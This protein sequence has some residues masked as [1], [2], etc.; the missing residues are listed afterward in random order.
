MKKL[1]LFIVLIIFSTTLFSQT[2][3][4]SGRVIDAISGEALPF[5]NIIFGQKKGVTTDINGRYTIK[6]TAPLD[7]IYLSFIGYQSKFFKIRN[8]EERNSVSILMDRKVFELKE[9][10]VIP[11]ENPAHRII[12]EAIK[13]RDNNNPLKNSSFSYTSYNKMV[14]TS[15]VLKDTSAMRAYAD[16][17][18][19]DSVSKMKRRTMKFFIDQ[20]LFM[21]ESVN[22][23][24]FKAPD[25]NFEKVIATKISGFKDPLF[26]LL[27]TQVQS[28]SFYNDMFLLLDKK[29]VNPI[30]SGSTSKYYFEIQDTTYR[31]NDTVFIISYRPRR[32]TN[33]DGLKGL[34]YINTNEYA[35][36]NVIAEPAKESGGFNISIQ[37]QYELIEQKK[38][39]PVQ[40]N[41]NFS[42]KN[43]QANGYQIIGNGTSFIQDIKLN[44]ALKNR[45]FGDTEVDLDVI[46]PEKSDTYLAHYRRDTLTP[47]EIRTY[48]IMD[49]IGKKENFEKWV[50]YSKT[51]MTGKI[52][53]GKIDLDISN[54]VR[55]NVY[56]GWRFDLGFYTNRRL[57]RNVSIGGYLARGLADL[58][59][60]YKIEGVWT[61]NRA[62]N[63]TL[64]VAYKDDIFESGGQPLFYDQ[65]TFLMV[66]LWCLVGGIRAML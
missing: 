63:T 14:F 39:F 51:L 19:Q 11:T 6:T 56:E 5:V 27:I 55:F 44:V 49:S 37:Q 32:G 61:I 3:T 2:Y 60:K 24:I 26:T 46:S 34:L 8:F 42:F 58:Y 41:T 64:S 57:M 59:N 10:V 1:L 16:T 29:F 38:W 28:I 4:Y 52:P 25:K 7:S 15:N 47:Q 62:K 23:R 45:E 35:I 54:F 50:N 31:D 33:F 12:N 20:H 53:I 40:L 21:M 9:F 65:K 17:T 48:L 30:S 13:N 43:I 36:Q 22:Q 18:L 66:I